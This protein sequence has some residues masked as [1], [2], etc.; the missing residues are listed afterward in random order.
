MWS[1]MISSRQ[2]ALSVKQKGTYFVLVSFGEIVVSICEV[3]TKLCL[4]FTM[5]YK[6]IQQLY[7]WH[8]AVFHLIILLSAIKH[9]S[10]D[11]SSVLI[12]QQLYWVL[13][14]IFLMISLFYFSSRDFHLHFFLCHRWQ[15]MFC[16]KINVEFSV[17]INTLLTYKYPISILHQKPSD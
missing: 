12:V 16:E 11:F 17:N 15:Q 9:N 6:M 8:Q 4:Y 3:E 2:M 5:A 1:I 13:F 10:Y 14:Q 7:F